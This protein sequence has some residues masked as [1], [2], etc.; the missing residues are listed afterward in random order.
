MTQPIILDWID[1]PQR[2]GYATAKGTPC[3]KMAHAMVGAISS[4]RSRG[5]PICGSHQR[6]LMRIWAEQATS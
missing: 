3:T 4:P 1:P 6:V 5:T 2:C